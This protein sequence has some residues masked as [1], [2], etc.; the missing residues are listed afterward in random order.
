MV[1][2]ADRDFLSPKTPE[3]VLSGYKNWGFGVE[4]GVRA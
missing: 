3:T 2:P 4:A 1:S